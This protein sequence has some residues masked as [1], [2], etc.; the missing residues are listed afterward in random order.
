MMNLQEGG[1]GGINFPLLADTSKTVTKAYGILVE[2]ETGAN[3]CRSRHALTE[4]LRITDAMYGASLRYAATSKL[5]K[6]H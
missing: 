6:S 1:L 2:D 5:S 4:F 3:K